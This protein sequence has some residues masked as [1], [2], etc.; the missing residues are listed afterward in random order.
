MVIY[1]RLF[2][3]LEKILHYW[4]IHGG[5][6]HTILNSSIVSWTGDV[7]HIWDIFK[8]TDEAF[9]KVYTRGS[10]EW[11]LKFADYKT[12]GKVCPSIKDYIYQQPPQF[13]IC[14]LGQ[15]HHLQ[16]KG[17]TGWYSNYFLKSQ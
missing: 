15:M 6:L 10:D 13:G 1:D 2:I 5:K 17:W 16:D 9:L 14:T 3:L 7:S 11:Y 8:A 12:Y 4:M